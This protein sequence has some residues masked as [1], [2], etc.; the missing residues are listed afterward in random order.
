[1]TAATAFPR[2][3]LATELFGDLQLVRV[4]LLAAA[5]AAIHHQAR[6]SPWRVRRVCCLRHI[7]LV[8]VGLGAATQNDMAVGIAFALDHYHAALGRGGEEM[9]G[10]TGLDGID[11]DPDIAVRTVLE[12]HGQ[13]A[14][15]GGQLPVDL[16]LRGACPDG[17]PADEIG[18]RESWWCRGI[19]WRW[20]APV[21]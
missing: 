21:H 12:S 20:R 18:E 15:C 6:G 7:A 14:K 2:L 17:A 11:G 1:M 19:R 8:V 16:R 10:G 3:Q 9:G 4:Q 13:W 5:M